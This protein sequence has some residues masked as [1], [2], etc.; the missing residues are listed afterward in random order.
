MGGVNAVTVAVIREVF[1]P[2]VR[3]RGWLPPSDVDC[4]YPLEG[5]VNVP[6]PFEED[7]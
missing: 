2:L 3:E 5:A 6:L 1:E 4:P 7:K